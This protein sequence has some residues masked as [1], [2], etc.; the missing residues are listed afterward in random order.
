MELKLTIQ[1]VK[2]YKSQPSE[3]WC[4]S[5]LIPI[6]EEEVDKVFLEEFLM[7]E[8]IEEIWDFFNEEF[9]DVLHDMIGGIS[10][11]PRARYSLE[12]SGEEFMKLALEE[13]RKIARKYQV[14]YTFTDVDKDEELCRSDLDI[15]SMM[16]EWIC[17]SGGDDG[18]SIRVGQAMINGMGRFQSAASW[19]AAWIA[20][21]N[22]LKPIMWFGIDGEKPEEG[23]ILNIPDD[24]ETGSTWSTFWFC[25]DSWGDWVQR[26]PDADNAFLTWV[27]VE[28]AMSLP[29]LSDVLKTCPVVI[30][31]NDDYNTLTQKI[32]A[33]LDAKGCDEP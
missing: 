19:Y 32:K 7:D 11:V 13:A 5:S 17:S 33:H 12:G 18:G 20:D 22:G 2:P 29:K 28:C 30:D 6:P 25:D 14:I 26:V 3:I 23:W 10:F 27:T 4:P 16:M 15:E 8:F 21:S 9:Y 24:H 31:E 1:V